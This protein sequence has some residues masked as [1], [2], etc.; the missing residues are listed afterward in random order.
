[1]IAILGIV[2]IYTVVLTILVEL[3][4]MYWDKN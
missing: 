4:K 3:I 1:M 2:I